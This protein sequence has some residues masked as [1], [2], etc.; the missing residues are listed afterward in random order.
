MVILIRCNDIVSDP[1]AMKYVRYLEETRQDYILIGWDRDGKMK[2][3]EKAIYYHRQ[4][5]YNVGG[6]HAVWNRIG[7]MQFVVRTLRSLN[8]EQATIHACD[9]DA[10]YPVV[11]YKKLKRKGKKSK[12]IFDVFDWFSAT[13]HEQPTLVLLAF[14]LME[15]TSVQGSNYIIICEPER[16]EQIPYTIPEEKL[17]VLP[18][19]P[20]FQ[21]LDFL[22]EN[23]EMHFCNGLITFSYVGG[24]AQS[25]CINEIISIAEKGL[26]NL[27]IAG[28]GDVQ[29]E[30]RLESLN[31]CLN[32]K[33]YGKVNYTDGL[34]VMYNSD[35]VYAMY[36]VKNPNHIY[37][38]PNKYYEAQMLGKPIFTT[39]GTIVEKKVV[40]NG[41]G[42]VSGESLEEIESIIK[43]VVKKDLE[44]KGV[45]ANSLWRDK[46]A[47]YTNNFM[48]TK[49]KSI[50][51][52]LQID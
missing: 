4:A 23:R 52:P 33:Y 32:I 22:S 13:L 35:I 25:R 46:F 26:I 20:Y 16:V 31:N 18:N 24:F 11:V 40:E 47:T 41:I 50:I 29:I 34:N 14:K 9:L 42:Y 51:T 19:I 21:N 7:W 1:R 43:D 44:K 8:I 17:L 36:S 38:A 10:A 2:D 3:T 15:K 45:K 5:G 39:K 27:A 30:K 37:A 6:L 49:Y 48:K 28:Y 12:I